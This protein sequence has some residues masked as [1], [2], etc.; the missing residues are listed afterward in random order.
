MDFLD[1][2]AEALRGF[3]ELVH[4]IGRDQWDDPTPCTE[5]TVR[6]LLGHLVYEQ[7]WAPDLLDGA[8]VEQVGDRYDGEQLGDHPVRRWETASRAARRAFEG[9][10]RETVHVSFGEIPLEDYGW[11]MTGDLAVHGWDLAVA[12]GA[13]Y[14]VGDELAE[15]LLAEL[16][17]QVSGWQ[18]GGIFAAPV[19]TAPDATPSDR[20][21][22]LLGRDPALTRSAL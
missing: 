5:W 19:R 4:R 7:L 8:T 10:G 13:E 14:R 17:P 3:D 6:D 18:G 9:T 20:L 12:I 11:Q 1:A 2:H 21:V 15:D 22:A 16:G